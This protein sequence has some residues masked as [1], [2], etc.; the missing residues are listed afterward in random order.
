[1]SQKLSACTSIL[2]GKKASRDGSIMIGRNEDAKAAWPKRLVVHAR[3]EMPSQFVSKDTKL[4]LTLP[5]ISARYTA[6][7]EWTDKYGLFEEAGINEYGVAMSATESA[8][9]NDLV[10]GY[11]PLVKEG[12]NEEAMVTVVLPYV[13]TARE[14]VQRLG[15]LV[16][17]YGTGETNG[18]LFADDDEAW[19]LETGAGH[20][21]VAQRI[22]DDCYAVV[23]NQLAIQEIDFNDPDNFIYHPGI[24]EFVEKNHLN[25]HPGTFNFRQIFGTADRS[26]AVYSEPRVWYG[27]QMFSPKAAQNEQ[28]EAADLPFLVKPERKLSIFDAQA[29]LGS[30]YEGTPFDPIGTGS[31]EEKHR[32]RPISLAKTQE[33]HIL[34]TSRASKN[35]IHWIAMGVANESTFVPFFSNINDT[36]APYKRGKLPAQLNSAYWI[37][38]HASVLVDS[39]LHDF[40]PMLRDVQK[41]CNAKAIAMIQATDEKAAGLAGAKLT[42]YLTRQSENFATDVLNAYRQLSL[43]LITKMTDYCPLNFNTDENL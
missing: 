13:K 2:I 20:Y 35:S 3:G 23:A 33:A 5:K 25:P 10:L 41:D 12:L 8:Y 36:P 22:P 34:Q 39:H 14:G 38:K 21:W 11:D 29:Y 1:M 18:I 31:D 16:A 37:F 32:Y 9:S 28:P 27:H 24:Q 17:K 4:E 7:P 43:E 26:D 40:L 19:Y 30:H 6:T 42:N 15:E